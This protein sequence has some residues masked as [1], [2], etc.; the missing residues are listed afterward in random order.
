M[1]SAIPKSGYFQVQD[2]VIGGPRLGARIPRH[3]NPK[4]KGVHH[5]NEHTKTYPN[6]VF[7]NHDHM[8]AIALHLHSFLYT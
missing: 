4:T 3:I 7:K 1:I 5:S 8:Q 2:Y 6:T